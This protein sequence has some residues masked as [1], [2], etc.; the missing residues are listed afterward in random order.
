[1]TRELTHFLAGQHVKGRS[2]RFSDVY[3]PATGEVTG[4]CPLASAEEVRAAVETARDA[5][6]GWA[7]TNPQRR[8]RVMM[9]FV[10]LLKRDMDRL[11]EALSAA[12]MARRCPMRAATCSA[13]SRSPSSASARRIC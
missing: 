8:A 7:A 2:G 1:M 9:E 5:Q 11:A 3:N 10:Q 12:S 13:G 6:P 4:R